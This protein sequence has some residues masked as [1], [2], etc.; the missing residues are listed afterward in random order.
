LN[1]KISNVAKR[2][3]EKVERNSNRECGSLSKDFFTKPLTHFQEYL[4]EY[5]E[6]NL[7]E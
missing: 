2:V 4:I 6:K 7:N 3:I 5:M 1:K